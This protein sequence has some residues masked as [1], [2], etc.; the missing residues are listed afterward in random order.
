MA[1]H[2]KKETETETEIEDTSI[3]LPK[4]TTVFYAGETVGRWL[5][6]RGTF[7]GVFEAAQDATVVEAMKAVIREKRQEFKCHIHMT[8]FTPILK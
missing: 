8:A 4:G 3:I 1:T 5:R 6:G 7:F 2:Y